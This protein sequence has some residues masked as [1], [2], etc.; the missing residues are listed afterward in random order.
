M[1]TATRTRPIKQNWY[2]IQGLNPDGSGQLG[3]RL[4][5][6][7]DEP[8]SG[9][10]LIQINGGTNNTT[11]PPPSPM[12]WLNV[13]AA[14][15]SSSITMTATTASDASGVEYFLDITSSHSVGTQK[16]TSGNKIFNSYIGG[17]GATSNTVDPEA[18]GT[19]HVT[20][21]L[22]LSGK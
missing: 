14:A 3:F 22:I 1:D 9:F 16:L 10:Q 2:R 12:T 15:G 11:P 17:A 19:T 5:D 8:L 21:P 6:L 20:K 13:P 7:A 4:G 18:L